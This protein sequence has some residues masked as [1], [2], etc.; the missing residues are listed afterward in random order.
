VI[1]SLAASRYRRTVAARLSRRR[2]P[3]LSVALVAATIALASLP[4]PT[5]AEPR[6]FPRTLSADRPGQAARLQRI[7]DAGRAEFGF[8]GVSVA[9]VF[10]DGTI[11]TGTSGLADVAKGIPVTRE[12]PFALASISKSFVAGVV[13][14]LIEE[15][16]LHLGDAVARLLPDVRLGSSSIDP[17][18][19]VRQLLD[20]TSGLHDFL[21]T[22]ALDRAVLAAPTEHWTTVRALSYV[23]RPFAE[24]GL[25]FYYS[26]TNYVLLGLI[27]ERLT[28]RTL[29]AELRDR[30]IEPLG[31]RTAT[32]QG[33]EPPAS[34]PAVAYRFTS[35]SSS[36]APIDMTDGSA[37]RPFTAITTAAGAA[38]S[39]MASAED[40]GRWLAALVTASSLRPATVARMVADAGRSTAVNPRFRYGLGLQA[41]VIDGHPSIGHSGRFL[42]QRAEARYFPKAGLTIVVLT[43]Q[44]RTDPAVIL[45][46]LL[47]YLIPSNAEL[48]L[49]AS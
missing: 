12:T 32:F 34:T 44:S 33:M 47:A 39:I 46:A 7:V 22:A 49:H 42:G 31:L 45:R 16:R 40:T 11:W 25:R 28:G 5:V 26:N 14:G 24:P 2:S 4:A 15:G 20:H 8:P 23:G 30:W 17:R 21:T 36:A 41:Y 18:I 6:S 13:M 19:T 48:A 35:G 3:F 27:V 1:E 10:P 43:N 37:I 29:A 38:G 9:V